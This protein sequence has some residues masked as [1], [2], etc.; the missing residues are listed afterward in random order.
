[1]MLAKHKINWIISQQ[2]QKLLL[3]FRNIGILSVLS[4]M[5]AW[6]ES[7][8]DATLLENQLYG[9]QTWLVY[10]NVLEQLSKIFKQFAT[11]NKAIN[12]KAS[13]ASTH[14]AKTLTCKAKVLTCKAK[15]LLNKTKVSFFWPQAKS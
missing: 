8:Y 5:R 6:W 3:R 15:I 4:D 2:S 12:T 10:T 14:K 13:M 9:V 11:V 7:H 1:M